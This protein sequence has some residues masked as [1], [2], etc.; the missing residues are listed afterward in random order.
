MKKQNNEKLSDKA[1]ARLALTSIL[2]IFCLHHLPLFDHL[3]VVYGQR[4]GG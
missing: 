1:F 3:C 2:G 4:A